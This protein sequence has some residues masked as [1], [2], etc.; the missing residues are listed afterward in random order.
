MENVFPPGWDEGRVRALI[1]YHESQT[2]DQVTEEVE[3]DL[4]R[5]GETLMAIPHGLLSVVL[6]LIEHYEQTQTIASRDATE[7]AS[8][9]FAI[10]LPATM[11]GGQVK[12]LTTAT[13]AEGTDLLVT[14]L[15][16]DPDAI[17]VPRGPSVFDSIWD[18]DEDDVYAELL[19][20]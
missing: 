6:D 17:D 12:L 1:A 13:L 16:Y 10:T 15:S 20:V 7:P 5:K 19:N 4:A 3:A 8:T 9:P 14:A 2:E 18:N 11:E